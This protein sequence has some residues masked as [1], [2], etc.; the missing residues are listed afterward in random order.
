MFDNLDRQVS[1]TEPLSHTTTTTYNANSNVVNFSNALGQTTS[2]GYDKSDR[3]IARLKQQFADG[4][5]ER[6]I[7][8][9]QNHT[10]RLIVKSPGLFEIPKKLP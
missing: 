8:Q 4:K 10:N 3:A 7:I 1:V 6:G 5:Y 9:M 2:Y